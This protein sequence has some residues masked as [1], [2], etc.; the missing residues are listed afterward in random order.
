MRRPRPPDGGREGREGPKSE[1]DQ[2]RRT[3]PGPIRSVICRLPSR[4]RDG[5]VTAG[6]PQGERERPRAVLRPPVRM[7]AV[8]DHDEARRRRSRRD[9][10]R[11]G[12]QPVSSA[13]RA[14]PPRSGAGASSQAADEEGARRAGRA[15]RRGAAARAPRGTRSVAQRSER[16]SGSACERRAPSARWR[17]RRRVVELRVDSRARPR[18][19][20]ERRSPRGARPMRS[21]SNAPSRP[22]STCVRGM[23][24]WRSSGVEPH[25]RARRAATSGPSAA[26]GDWATP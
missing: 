1:R 2:R 12:N 25:V 16:R 18:R 13:T 15:T 14:R 21:T 19:R 23:S 5:T 10:H 24:A 4:R 20:I 26:A 11:C 17:G 22:S 9:P 7:V 6:G 3:P 8:Q